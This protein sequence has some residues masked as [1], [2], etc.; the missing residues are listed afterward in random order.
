MKK[1]ELIDALKPK[2]KI[3]LKQKIT[4]TIKQQR[5]I[6]PPRT[7]K[8]ERPIP[9]PRTKK[10]ERPIPAP[11]RPTTLLKR[12]VPKINIPILEPAPHM[13]RKIK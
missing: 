11:R 3:Q 13:L 1:A 8:A 2:T 5:P 12:I 10:A 6:P 7:N 9:A 4:K